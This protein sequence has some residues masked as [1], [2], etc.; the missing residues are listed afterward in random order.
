MLETGLVGKRLTVID[1][2]IRDEA[3]LLML[4]IDLPEEDSA[5]QFQ[6][7][8]LSAVCTLLNV[9]VG[10]NAKIAK[11]N[12]SYMDALRA[13]S[14]IKK[15]SL[16][17]LQHV[18]T[19]LVRGGLN[20]AVLEVVQHAVMLPPADT[21]LQAWQTTLQNASKAACSDAAAVV[22]ALQPFEPKTAA[23]MADAAR[24]RFHSDQTAAGLADLSKALDLDPNDAQN[25]ARR[26][27]L[28]AMQGDIAGTVADLQKADSISPLQDFEYLA[29]QGEFTNNQNPAYAV[30]IFDRALC[31]KPITYPPRLAYA[32]IY[33]QRGACKGTLQQ[34]ASAVED[35]DMALK[36]GSRSKNIY[37]Q[38]QQPVQNG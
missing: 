29:L 23:S 28:K 24:L 25:L 22:A 36:L 31:A 20:Q 8:C 12:G 37:V 10:P 15:L 13:Q 1:I 17:M 16:P 6:S 11:L 4:P 26:G 27:Y 2:M 32:R 7:D 9:N 21:L 18:V 19:V 5:H 3:L 35:L 30:S 34:C 14:V 33:Q 38:K